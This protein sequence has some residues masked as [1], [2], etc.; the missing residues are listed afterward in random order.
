M[1]ENQNQEQTPPLLTLEGRSYNL[2]EVPDSVKVLVD[3]LMRIAREVAEL[4]FKLRQSQ[5]SQ[6]AYIATIEK[7]IKDN[8]IEPYRI[9]DSNENHQ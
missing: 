1:E 2:L 8:N 5:L 9:D 7:E 3:D 4:Q 6:Q